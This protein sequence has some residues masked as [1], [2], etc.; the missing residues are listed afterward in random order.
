MGF[1]YTTNHDAGD[2][3]QTE[4][5]TVTP[6]QNKLRVEQQTWAAG[7]GWFTQKSMLLSEEQAHTLVREL[8]QGLNL[9]KMLRTAPNRPVETTE[10]VP[11][12]PVAKPE[13]L[14]F[15]TQR[16]TRASSSV[17]EVIAETSD[18]VIQFRPRAKKA[19]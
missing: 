15:P 16:A 2:G 17:A 14:T 10:S 19:R 6:E 9:A 13:P 1:S 4:R 7:M 3:Q 11:Q 8:Q 5:F 18:N 12:T